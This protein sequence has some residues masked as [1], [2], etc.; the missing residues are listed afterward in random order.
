MEF[1]LTVWW[2]V[3]LSEWQICVITLNTDKKRKLNPAGMSIIL[4]LH[5]MNKLMSFLI[6]SINKT[7]TTIKWRGL[8][9]VTSWGLM[10]YVN[11]VVISICTYASKENFK[12]KALNEMPTTS[13]FKYNNNYYYI[14]NEYLYVP[15]PVPM[16]CLSDVSP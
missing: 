5:I 14:T 6:H 16:P 1:P 4:N 10:W 8:V 12:S 15:V 7:S 9:Y 13:H 11:F 3:G 2:M